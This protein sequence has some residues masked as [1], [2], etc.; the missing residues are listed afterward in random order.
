MAVPTCRS[1]EQLKAEIKRIN[2]P[3]TCA[4]D[5]SMIGGACAACHALALDA[6]EK[7]VMALGEIGQAKG[8][9][10]DHGDA[11]DAGLKALHRGAKP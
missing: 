9:A 5:P 1:C 6:L 10:A 3:F 11:L 2:G 4:H 7:C 8:L